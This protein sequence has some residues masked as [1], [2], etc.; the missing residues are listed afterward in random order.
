MENTAF[1]Q[2]CLLFQRH[3]ELRHTC[4]DMSYAQM[5]IAHR[6]MTVCSY[7]IVSFPTLLLCFQSD[8]RTD[9]NNPRLLLS[10]IA[11]ILTTAS[12]PSGARSDYDS[13]GLMCE[14]TAYTHDQNSAPNLVC[15]K[16]FTLSERAM[17]FVGGF[18]LQVCYLGI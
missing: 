5:T 6:L 16:L 12:C 3:L 8:C 4:I 11:L 15:T 14:V 9:F 18:S 1:K 2:I 17:L 10:T 7:K 13:I